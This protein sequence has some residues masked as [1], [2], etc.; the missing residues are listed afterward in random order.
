M[1]SI[2]TVMPR[3]RTWAIGLL[4][5]ASV[6]PV[7]TA[8]AEEHPFILWTRQEAA[9]TRRKIE[10]EPWPKK[11]YAALDA[12]RKR[13]GELELL[14]RYGVMGD[15]DAGLAEKKALLD[16]V[17]GGKAQGKYIAPLRYDVLYDLLTPQERT[18]VERAF[19]AYIEM[20]MRSMR[21][22]DYNRYNWLPNLGYP[23]YL[24]AHLMA[25]S[26]RDKE[27]AREVFESPFGLK[28]YLDEYLSDQGFYNEEFGKMYNTPDAILLWG[29]ACERLGIDEI[30]FGYRG[31]QG[32]T[33]RGHIES[34]LRI[35]MPRVD[36]GTSRPHYPRLSI[37][38]AKGPRG[39]PAYGFQHYL[40]AGHLE[41]RYAGRE[42]SKWSLG[43]WS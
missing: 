32:A 20:G 7:G 39:V 3:T 9:A 8:V 12:P 33:I 19:R 13:R 22:R 10:R 35:G 5:A 25:V 14:F 34:V 26:M 23:W 43:E 21:E 41:H 31:R 1:T 37:G 38:D 30:G 36:L 28:W 16:S 6:L 18:T 29:R 15:K 17:S 42:Y 24:S 40:V 2:N 4:L 11:A 27:L